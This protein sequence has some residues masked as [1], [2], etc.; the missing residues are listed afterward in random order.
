MDFFIDN[1]Y[2]Q[3]ALEHVKG[4]DWKAKA[5][6]LPI[7]RSM[8]KNLLEVH[9]LAYI[10]SEIEE[11][12]KEMSDEQYLLDKIFQK[13]QTAVKISESRKTGARRKA[14]DKNLKITDVARKF[15][16]NPDSRGKIEC[17]FHDDEN[18]SCKLDDTRNTFYCF[19]CQA[20]GDIVEFY[21]RFKDEKTRSNK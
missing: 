8:T 18:P 4:F 15:G 7:W 19:G 17:P 12:V 1:L 6:Q 3:V 2:R 9:S 21:R 20:K 5:R 14:I 16:L 11:C 10:Y 13:S